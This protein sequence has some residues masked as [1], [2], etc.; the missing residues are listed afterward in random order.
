MAEKRQDEKS[1]FQGENVIV[2]KTAPQGGDVPSIGHV[3][4]ERDVPINSLLKAA[5]YL[6]VSIGVI[7]LALWGLFEFFA[8]RAER[9]DPQISPLAEH[10]VPPGPKL[11]SNPARELATFRK[12]EDSILAAPGGVANDGSR[13]VSVDEAMQMIAEHGLPAFP[14]AAPDTTRR[15][16]GGATPAPAT[17]TSTTPSTTPA[18]GTTTGR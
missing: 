1:I 15:A 17:P 14:S 18:G 4:E 10:R 9:A 8:A 11:Q 12:R 13:R 6:V 3:H 7:C 5:A 2:R 16:A